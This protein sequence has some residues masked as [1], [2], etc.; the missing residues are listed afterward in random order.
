MEPA[1]SIIAKLGGVAKVAS[2][3]GIHR[4]RVSNWKRAREVGGT[5]GRIPQDH[6]LT[7]LDYA[8][9]NE[10]PLSAADFLPVHDEALA[11]PTDRTAAVEG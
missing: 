11:P 10:I 6:H 3:A 2:L 5:G 8:R 1:S 4:T 9:A 7:L